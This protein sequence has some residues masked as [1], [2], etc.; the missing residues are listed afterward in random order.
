MDFL[1]TSIHV[2]DIEASL[3]FYT[4]VV[5]LEVVRQMELP[6][7]NKMAF[8]GKGETHL[9]LI[10]RP[11]HTIETY[12]KDISIGFKVDSVEETMKTVIEAG[13]EI[14]MGPIQPSPHIKF[15]FVLDPMGV[16]VQF[17]E[18]MGK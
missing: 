8:L 11:D 7:G 10:Y 4:E 14:Y 5:K 18:M 3:K 9:E 16:N 17:V 13:Y 2:T 1:W 6:N 15:F 12:S